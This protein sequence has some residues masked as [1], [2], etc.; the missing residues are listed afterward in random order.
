MTST[1]RLALTV[2]VLGVFT[3]VVLPLQLV[4]IHRGWRVATTLPYTWQRLAWWLIGMKVQVVGKPAPAPLLIASNHSSWLD[5]TVLGGLFQPL[6][7]VAKAE[8]ARWP[9]LGIARQAAA[10]DLHRPDAA[11]AHRRRSRGGGAPG[12]EGRS[13]RPLRRRHHGQTGT[14]SSRSGAR[15][16][17]RRKTPP[18]IAVA[19]VQ[20]WRSAMSG[21]RAF[22]SGGATGR[23]SPG[24]ATWTSSRISG[25]SSARVRSMSW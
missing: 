24:M 14:A 11:D 10:H 23:I 22:R 15:C 5:I 3:I 13:G 25:E 21:S 17:A 4:A 2:L 9:V 19:T 12:G 8:V 16:S 1:L 20:P 6:S 18:A 7:F